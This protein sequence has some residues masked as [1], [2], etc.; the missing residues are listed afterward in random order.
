MSSVGQRLADVTS[1]APAL[2]G[3]SLCC[4]W[5]MQVRAFT[6]AALVTHISAL[7]DPAAYFS[8]EKRLYTSVRSA[9]GTPRDSVNAVA[10]IPTLA[11]ALQPVG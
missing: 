11:E 5:I 7:L 2:S 8:S 6:T 1:P 9:A 4:S 3:A 10:Q